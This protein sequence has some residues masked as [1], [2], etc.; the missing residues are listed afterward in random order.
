[1]LDRR[2][3][4]RNNASVMSAAL[5][6]AGVAGSPAPP[7]TLFAELTDDM[8]KLNEDELEGVAFT[9]EQRSA[10]QTWA[11]R[12]RPQGIG[13]VTIERTELFEEAAEVFLRWADR[14]T[15]GVY[16]RPNGVLVLQDWDFG[17]EEEYPTVEAALARIE[18]VL[19][20]ADRDQDELPE[21]PV[22]SFYLH[23]RIRRP[24]L[25]DDQV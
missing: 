24:G 15:W 1:M 18:A 13:K 22:H 17:G 25:V 9:P 23:A 16:R 8:T 5:C 21:R 3:L 10:L 12:M 6:G 7:T 11:A 14:A 20:A 19:D 2:V 4:N